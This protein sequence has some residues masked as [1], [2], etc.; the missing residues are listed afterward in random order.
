MNTNIREVVG[1]TQQPSSPQAVMSSPQSAMHRTMKRISVASNVAPPTL[2][3]RSNLLPQLQMTALSQ[4]RLDKNIQKMAESGYEFGQQQSLIPGS[5]RHYR[6]N[7]QITP[8]SALY[9]KGKPRLSQ[10]RTSLNEYQ[11]M[12]ESKNFT[13]QMTKLG[14]T[15]CSPFLQ[16]QTEKNLLKSSNKQI[17]IG[18]P[19][20]TAKLKIVGHRNRQLKC[21]MYN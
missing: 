4:A 2:S 9:S 11:S 1:P 10:E 13:S 8:L 15:G 21:N 3:Q 12:S 19:Q 14:A 7:V 5:A 16:S 20:H 6:S 17:T 18:S